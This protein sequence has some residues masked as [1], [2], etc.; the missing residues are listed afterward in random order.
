MPLADKLCITYIEDT[1]EQ[2]D[3]FFP[4]IDKNIWKE[5]NREKHTT[6]EKH[7]YPYIF[8]DYERKES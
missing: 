2:A 1:P 3:A 7:S 4:L 6:D 5:T 8:I